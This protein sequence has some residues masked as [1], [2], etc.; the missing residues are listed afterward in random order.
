MPTVFVPYDRIE[1]KWQG[2]LVA[3]RAL[4]RERWVVTEKVHGANFVVVGEPGERLRYA[5]PEGV[6]CCW[7]EF[8]WS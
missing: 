6:A 2:D 1:E 7:G 5:K 4:A 8:F 3:E